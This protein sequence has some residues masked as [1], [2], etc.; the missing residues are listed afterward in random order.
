[1]WALP[2]RREPEGFVIAVAVAVAVGICR[3]WEVAQG[4]SQ[5]Y[6][7]SSFHFYREECTEP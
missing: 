3:Y 2:D 7:Y 5:C 1:M 6:I 4:V